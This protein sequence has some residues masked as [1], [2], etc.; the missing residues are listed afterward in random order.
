[1]SNNY[2]LIQPFYAQFR[3]K[4]WVRW[5]PGS[6]PFTVN[7]QWFCWWLD[8]LHHRRGVS[9][10][11]PKLSRGFSRM[12]AHPAAYL[13]QLSLSS[14]YKMEVVLTNLWPCDKGVCA[15]LHCWPYGSRVTSSLFII[16]LHN[17]LQTC[18]G[19]WNL[20][21]CKISA[22]SSVA[23]DHQGSSNC[24]KMQKKTGKSKKTP[25]NIFPVHNLLT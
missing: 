4:C 15:P 16:Y 25:S 11:P 3:T 2:L 14:L 8:C 5:V 7:C 10:V 22:I 9:I 12:P 13:D 21:V 23:F 24:Q 1:M 20:W 18:R 19:S 6:S 17:E